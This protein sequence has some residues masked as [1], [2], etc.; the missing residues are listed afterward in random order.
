MTYLTATPLTAVALT[1]SPLTALKLGDTVAGFSILFSAPLM[2]S[3]VA[4][5]NGDAT[6]TYSRGSTATFIDYDGLVRIAASGEARFAGARRVQNIVPDSTTFVGWTEVGAA[7]IDSAVG[8]V[9]DISGLTTSTGNR[10]EEVVLSGQSI[11]TKKFVYSF[12]IKGEGTNVG[13]WARALIGRASGSGSSISEYMQLTGDFQSIEVTY[14]AA[15]DDVGL[16]MWLLGSS[17]GAEGSVEEMTIRKVQV[18]EVQGRSS[19]SASEYVSSGL[20]SPYHGANIDGVEYFNT[21]V[22]DGA[23]ISVAASLSGAKYGDSLTNSYGL[24]MDWYTNVPYTLTTHSVGGSTSSAAKI[25]FDANYTSAEEFTI[26]GTGIND[27]GNASTDPNTTIQSNVSYMADI[28]LAAGG[29][30]VLCG[31]TPFKNGASWSAA[32]QGWTDTYNTWAKTNYP[33]NFVDM[34]K[35]LGDPADSDALLAAYDSGDGVHLS[36]AGQR[37]ADQFIN[38]V[39]F[40]QLFH[41]YNQRGPYGYYDEGSRTNLALHSRDLSNAVW[42]KTNVTAA[43]DA[44]GMDGVS[45]SAS[46]ATATAG[47]ATCIQSITSVSATRALSFDLRRVV[48]WG[49]IELTI[50]GG[51]TYTDISDQIAREGYRRVQITQTAVTNPQIG[52]RI[53]TSGDSIEVDFAGLEDARSASSRIETTTGSVTRSVDSLSYLVADNLLS[54]T[55]TVSREVFVEWDVANT[56]A[57]NMGVNN[58]YDRFGAV[59]AGEDAQRFRHQASGSNIINYTPA[60]RKYSIA[61]LVEFTVWDATDLAARAF[62]VTNP[63]TPA[64]LVSGAYDGSLSLATRF[65]VGSGASGDDANYG[66][67]RGL[68]IYRDRMTESQME[69]KA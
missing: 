57:Y 7:N 19:Q 17:S 37:V 29:N 24:W 21:V 23:L 51:T 43:K 27:I 63:D 48:G 56:T 67:V 52:F 30:L 53:E 11:A 39:R 60:N 5:G 36:T 14:T 34:H 25:V 12:D 13:K 69:A 33:N 28:V 2:T 15:S 59:N 18:E 38:V 6:P 44:I 35:L 68:K 31:I 41:S 3:L 66:T 8:G 1:A 16:Q 45:A 62:D 10:L 9:V 26:L 64:V 4:T 22:E 65:T 47:N 40:K 50:D 42:A 55:G 20:A 46:T 49:K 58:G 61:P 54:A 32:R